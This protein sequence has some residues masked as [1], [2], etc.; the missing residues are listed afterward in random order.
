LVLN[1]KGFGSKLQWADLDPEYFEEGMR[2]HLEKSVG[3]IQVCF[4]M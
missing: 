3:I 1:L 2:K 4:R